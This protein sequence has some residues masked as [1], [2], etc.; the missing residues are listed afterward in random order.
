MTWQSNHLMILDD[1]QIIWYWN[2]SVWLSDQDITKYETYV[3]RTIDT[4]TT[5]LLTDAFNPNNPEM[6]ALKTELVEIKKLLVPRLSSR[7]QSKKSNKKAF[8]AGFPTDEPNEVFSN[9]VYWN[10]IVRAPTRMS[11]RLHNFMLVWPSSTNYLLYSDWNHRCYFSGASQTGSTLLVET[12]KNN[13][14]SL[15]V[16]LKDG[17]KVNFAVENFT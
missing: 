12:T 1:N 6:L 8:L 2:L 15:T 5:V 17:F 10:S 9:C 14:L 11:C 3:V 13:I 4:N 7:D 16:L